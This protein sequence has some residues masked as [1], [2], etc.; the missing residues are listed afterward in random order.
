MEHRSLAI[1]FP[2]QSIAPHNSH[3]TRPETD[4]AELRS[5][6]F[7]IKD[8]SFALLVNRKIAYLHRTAR[9]CLEQPGIWNNILKGS[10][11]EFVL[12]KAMLASMIRQLKSISNNAEGAI[13]L[14]DTIHKTLQYLS[15]L[16]KK[17]ILSAKWTEEIAGVMRVSVAQCQSR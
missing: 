1:V 3:R 17:G 4:G 12:Y 8:D 16:E 10:S 5:K 7:Q 15:S 13:I 14:S 9:D 6:P 11:R 2:R